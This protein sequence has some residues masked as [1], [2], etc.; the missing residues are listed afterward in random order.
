MV[1]REKLN[2][3]SE[4]GIFRHHARDLVSTEDRIHAVC[5]FARNLLLWL[6]LPLPYANTQHI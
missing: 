4:K 1:V 6:Q 2:E 5:R 3:T